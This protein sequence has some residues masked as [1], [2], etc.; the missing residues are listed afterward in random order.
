[1]IG[2]QGALK[3]LIQIHRFL[4]EF[5]KQSVHCETRTDLFELLCRL[6]V[7]QGGYRLA[8][9]GIQHGDRIV[10]VA[11][12]GDD[13]QRVPQLNCGPS[14]QQSDPVVRSIL[15]NSFSVLNVSKDLILPEFWQNLISRLRLQAVAV[16]PIRFKQKIV[17]VFA[18]C[19]S[20]QD[21]F[22][23][24]YS[25]SLSEFEEDISGALEKL[26]DFARRLDM[27]LQ[28][29]Q[30]HLAVESSAT[31]V[32]VSD[33]RGFIQ[34]VNPHFSEL[35]GYDT[36][37][38][39]G[40]SFTEFIPPDFDRAVVQDMRAQLAAGQQWH[41]ESRIMTRQGESIWI[42]QQVSPITDNRNVVTHYVCTLVDHTELHEA[43]ETIEKMAY[44]DELT[45]L[46]NRR[47]FN[48]RLQQ[49]IHRASR[50]KLCFAVCFL[51]LDGFKNVN[52]TLGH[53]A[54]DQ[55]LKTVSSRIRNQ[56]R[57]KDTLARLGGDEFTLI[58]TDVK[59]PQ[60]CSRV[61]ANIIRALQDPIQIDSRE[62]VVTT[63]IGIAH[64]P[65]DGDNTIDLCRHA[66]MAMY[67]AKS[68]GRNNFQFFTES[69]NQKAEV[70]LA[71]ETELHCALSQGTFQL[72]YQPQIAGMDG[73]L[74]ALEAMLYWAGSE[75]YGLSQDELYLNLER[76]GMLA[77]VFEWQLMQA[78]HDSVSAMGTFGVQFRLAIRL[79][80]LMLRNRDD[81]KQCLERCLLKSGADCSLLQFEVPE[82][83]F[84]NEFN[85]TVSILHD[86][87]SKG[88]S[89]VID[90]FGMGGASLRFLSRFKVDLL[91]IDHGLVEEVITDK[92][93][94]AVTSAIIALAHQLN[95]KV[96]ANG[97]ETRMHYQYLERYW[98][99]YLQ[100]SYMAP[101]MTRSQLDDYLLQY[102][103]QGIQVS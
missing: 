26:D 21:D 87:R 69:L 47:L 48:D 81:F 18:L 43:H 32:L 90:Q 84:S 16:V 4:R 75:H 76:A 57:T 97:V 9:V 3:R 89:I 51:D 6:A 80:G 61:S 77:D 78:C 68:K 40:I 85:N 79:P 5:N 31:A 2:M 52:D 96:L 103:D 86:L 82:T 72:R 46:P 102:R 91:K 23:D 34:Y 30:L 19:S 14:D 39:L 64:Y 8:W 29:K 73:S 36:Y 62:V 53:E 49:E 7:E 22:S 94:A 60:D 56:I 95:L 71:L 88:A 101:A 70:Q 33:E 99:D 10:P 59:T 42:Y 28:L 55:L 65:T 92:N 17:G 15:D 63:S 38:V 98:C 27:E 20:R 67:Y 24:L 37:E 83:A 58:I 74:R 13:Q 45:G 11:Q 44:Y 50:D 66:D 12:F 35:T 41:G 54:G 93:D 25:F 100:G 1:M